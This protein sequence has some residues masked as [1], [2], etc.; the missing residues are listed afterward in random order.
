MGRFF[1]F[2]CIVMLLIIMNS[3]YAM[4]K[5]P[6]DDEGMADHKM[7]LAMN[8]KAGAQSV[9]TFLDTMNRGREFTLT[10]KDFTP[11]MAETSAVSDVKGDRTEVPNGFR[12]QCFASSQIE[13]VRAE[14]KMLESKI[15]YG[16]YIVFSAPYYKLL[17]G[18]FVKRGDADAACAKLKELGYSDAWVL[19]TK[20]WASHQDDLFPYL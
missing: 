10:E 12:V 4:S 17:V 14:Q 20:V 1:N 7:L 3:N 15:R 2:S 8:D 6:K 13:R 5:R 18:D 11:I 16:V 19:R 9:E